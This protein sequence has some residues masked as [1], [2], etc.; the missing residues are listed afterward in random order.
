MSRDRGNLIFQTSY[1]TQLLIPAALKL[2]GDEA[3]I[4]IDRVVLAASQIR[5]VARLLQSQFKL[6]LLL[7][8]LCRSR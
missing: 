6:S 8:R 4:G 2:S 5:L 3:V 1:L 7:G